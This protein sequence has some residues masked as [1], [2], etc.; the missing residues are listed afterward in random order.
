MST[1]FFNNGLP[2]PAKLNLCL[3]I[4]N[5]KPDGYHELQT[6]YRL[7]DLQDKVF[8]Q[9]REDTLILYADNLGTSNIE[10]NTC[11][12]AA[13][14]LQQ[15]TGCDLGVEL[16]L[17]K[18]IPI[19]GGLGGGSS[20]AATVI[21][22]LNLLWECGLNKEQLSDLCLKVGADVPFFIFGYSAWAE[23]IGE[24]FSKIEVPDAWYLVIKPPFEI[25]TEEIFNAPE[26]TR[27][28][29]PITIGD[30]DAHF[31]GVNVFEPVV[32]KR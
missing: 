4:L 23:G 27:N 18:H 31:I 22:G 29:A 20:D 13:E 1:S 9:P 16:Y 8:M 25:S 15:S 7:I 3:N 6:V 21:Y 32:R 5:R 28:N 2:A 14:V 10:D 19:G 24:R 26:L 11:I 30:V 17:E 12:R